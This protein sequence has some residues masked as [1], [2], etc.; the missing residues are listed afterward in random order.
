M[1]D[2]ISFRVYSRSVQSAVTLPLSFLLAKLPKS[3][4]LLATSSRSPSPVLYGF[5]G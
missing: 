1:I 2:L 4:S 3:G 5:R